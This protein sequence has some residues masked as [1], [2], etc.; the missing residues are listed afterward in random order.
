M[1]YT[2]A[3]N[4][5]DPEMAR[6]MTADLICPLWPDLQPIISEERSMCGT[7]YCHINNKDKSDKGWIR[8]R[9]TVDT[10]VK[11]EW[12]TVEQNEQD[13]HSHKPC[14]SPWALCEHWLEL[15]KLTTSHT[16]LGTLLFLWLLSTSE[17]NLL[18]SNI[19]LVANGGLQKD[20][21]HLVE[22]LLLKHLL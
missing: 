7:G 16:Q 2:W 11:H 15:Q 13:T 4:S 9:M 12:C 17:L 5:A 1:K 21:R 14:V 22:N 8:I 19:L 3:V 20:N 18:L 10:C 6:A